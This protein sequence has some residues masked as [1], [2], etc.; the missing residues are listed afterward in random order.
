MP[1]GW[2]DNS[3]QLAHAL[4]ISAIVFE[5][6]ADI[7]EN[8]REK[9]QFLVLPVVNYHMADLGELPTRGTYGTETGSWTRANGRP[10]V[11]VIFVSGSVSGSPLDFEHVHLFQLWIIELVDVKVFS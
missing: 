6:Y 9:T 2:F 11:D 3:N 5:K 1:I 10:F 7:K 8:Q 4:M